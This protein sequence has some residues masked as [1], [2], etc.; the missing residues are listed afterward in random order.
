MGGTTLPGE[1]F[2]RENLPGFA[3]LDPAEPVKLPLEA[4]DLGM[5]VGFIAVW[6]YLSSIGRGR[7]R[8]MPPWQI[9]ATL[10]IFIGVMGFDGINAFAYD[11][12]QKIPALPYLYEPRLQLRLATGLLTGIAF[13]GILTP[14]VN[15]ALWRQDDHRPIIANWKHL[16]GALGVV[17]IV[18]II[19]ESHLG[20]FL[21]PLAIITS[22]SVPILV[23]LI[24]MV[25][26]LS[27]F[28]RE[29]NALTWRDALN[30]FAAGV[31]F[32]LIEL[33][34]LSLLRYAI[35]GTAPIP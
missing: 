12:H 21:Y 5:Y 17:A 16:A 6:V 31:A 29:G 14:V 28:R 30:P 34:I 18:Y 27:I 33:G 24:N 8:G 15:Y 35:L 4:R 2:L 3:V 7:A 10:V 1:A 22:A 13:A 11:L 23:G 32:A 9:T 19:N 25:F 26:L 20:L